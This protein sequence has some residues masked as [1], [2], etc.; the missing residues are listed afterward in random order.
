MPL[1]CVDLALLVFFTHRSLNYSPFVL[2]YPQDLSCLALGGVVKALFE[3]TAQ[4][5]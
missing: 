5:D 3:A 4:S 1:L 2:N